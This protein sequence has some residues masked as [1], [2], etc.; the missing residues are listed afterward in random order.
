MLLEPFSSNCFGDLCLWCEG[1]LLEVEHTPTLDPPTIA[2]PPT[3]LLPTPFPISPPVY[4][5]PPWL[6][7]NNRLLKR[8]P[9]YSPTALLPPPPPH[10]CPSLLPAH[11]SPVATDEQPISKNTQFYTNF[12]NFENFVSFRVLSAPGVK[13]PPLG[14][15]NRLLH[16]F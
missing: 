15:C 16:S 8:H 7:S 13:E 12:C 9:H 6:R 10:C 2:R 11:H 5:P 3:A 4:P 14:F 1:R